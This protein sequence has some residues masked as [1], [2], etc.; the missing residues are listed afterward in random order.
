MKNEHDVYLQM[1]AVFGVFFL[2]DMRYS[3][4]IACLLFGVVLLDRVEMESLRYVVFGASLPILAM[5][6]S[7]DSIVQNRRGTPEALCLLVLGIGLRVQR[8]M[9]SVYCVFLG[10]CWFIYAYNVDEPYFDFTVFCLVACVRSAYEWY[11]CRE[12][13]NLKTEQK[14]LHDD[15]CATLSDI[16]KFESMVWSGRKPEV[17]L[18]V[19]DAIIGVL[20]SRHIIDLIQDNMEDELYMWLQKITNVSSR[21]ESH[22]LGFHGDAMVFYCQGSLKKTVDMFKHLMD[23]TT[24]SAACIDCLEVE[25]RADARRPSLVGIDHIFDSIDI[26]KLK[27]GP[28]FQQRMG[29][30][31]EIVFESKTGSCGEYIEIPAEAP[32]RGFV[33]KWIREIEEQATFDIWFIPVQVYWAV[34]PPCIFLIWNLW[35]HA[36]VCTIVSLCIVVSATYFESP[37]SISLFLGLMMMWVVQAIDSFTVMCTLALIPGS[38]GLGLLFFG[39]AIFRERTMFVVIMAVVCA[40]SAWCTAMRVRENKTYKRRRADLIAAFAREDAKLTHMWA[41]YVPKMVRE[42]VPRSFDQWFYME[43][44]GPCVVAFIQGSPPEV[45]SSYHVFYSLNGGCWVLRE[46][47]SDFPQGAEAEMREIVGPNAI[48]QICDPKVVVLS[49]NVL[50]VSVFATGQATP[51]SHTQIAGTSNSRW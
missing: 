43:D 3:I 39:A 6:A 32:Q 2:E 12:T 37:E 40:W 47:L 4:V 36:I 29:L 5:L 17:S 24:T 8:I 26:G 15:V 50:I 34:I 18:N 23:K 19:P 13:R 21:C 41:R 51:W 11:Y 25:F 7:T 9:G 33:R 20:Y 16:E 1:V 46:G 22:F 14:K 35:A 27:V 45:P 44:L 28:T 31:S 30:K 42:Q 10:L 49:S 48:V 38:M